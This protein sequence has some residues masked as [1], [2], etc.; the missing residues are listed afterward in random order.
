MGYKIPEFQNNLNRTKTEY[1]N[2][3]KKN[4]LNFEIKI[5]VNIIFSLY[6][7]IRFS[8]GRTGVKGFYY[9]FKIIINEKPTD[10]LLDK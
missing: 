9:H 3:K 4:T 10:V 7:V 8:F 6:A 2:K 1:F 5:T